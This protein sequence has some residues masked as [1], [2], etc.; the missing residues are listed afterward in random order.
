MK[1]EMSF[2]SSQ[3][4]VTSYPQQFETYLNENL[5]RLSLDLQLVGVMEAFPVFVRVDYTAPTKASTN[6]PTNTPTIASTGKETHSPL[7]TNRYLVFDFE[8]NAPS[9]EIVDH[10]N[11]LGQN[12]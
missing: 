4:D 10:D 7:P 3:I 8:T 6:E 9:N 12:G 1:Y 5:E 11:N 2:T